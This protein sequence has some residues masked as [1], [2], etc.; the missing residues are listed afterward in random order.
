MKRKLL[1][2]ICMEAFFCAT[3]SEE[4]QNTQKDRF[5]FMQQEIRFL[6]GII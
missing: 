4:F 3:A 1:Y 2:N 5:F 6:G